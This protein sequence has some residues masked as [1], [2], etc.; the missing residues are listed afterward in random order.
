MNCVVCLVKIT[1]TNDSE[2]HIIPASI[3]GKLKKRGVLC[4]T[5]NN[6]AGD[7][8][9]SE[10]AKQ[11]NFF[12]VG[13]NVRRD[14]GT[15]P[16]EKVQTES[17]EDLLL[18][19]G[20]PMTPARPFFKAS[21]VADGIAYEIHARSMD[22]A[23]RMVGGLAKK[24]SSIDLEWVLAAAQV[25]SQQLDEYLKLSLN[26]G[27]P[28]A[29]RSVVKSAL[30]WAAAN[31]V[32]AGDCAEAR[33]YL[34]QSTANACFGFL[35]AT[36]PILNRPVGI[37]FHGVAVSSRGTGGQ[38]LGYVEFFG[39]R[40]VV[41]RL[42]K[43]YFGAEVHVSHF[44]DPRTG[45]QLQLDFQLLFDYKEMKAIFDY[46]R[47]LPDEV[48]ASA[49]PII[50]ALLNTFNNAESS[51]ASSEMVEQAFRDCGAS[52]GETLTNEHLDRVA[53]SIAKQILN[54]QRRLRKH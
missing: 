36:D 50:E 20:K 26:F 27:G 37:P 13:F 54:Y 15:P 40:R 30:C 17:G 39:W 47:C 48:A 11:L 53:K 24:H 28:L 38:L 35:N 29:G 14:R 43:E 41:V 1:P 4:A 7:A 46:K 3:G 16:A 10:L 8:W 31:G 25:R 5:C 6:S 44:I 52:E 45:N 32:L 9:D 42:A 51:R 12:S 21:P 23:R 22:E 34:T 49:A 33:E 18:H 2:E 19:A